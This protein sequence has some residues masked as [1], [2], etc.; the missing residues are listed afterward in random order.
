MNRRSFLSTSLASTA[1]A[2]PLVGNDHHSKGGENI[3]SGEKLA[4]QNGNSYWPICLDTATLDKGIGI[5]QKLRLAAE[6][7]FD[8]KEVELGDAV[9]ASDEVAGAAA[10]V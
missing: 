3:Q 2:A 10:V 5:E 4:W 1:V 6:A 8:V 9:S 7:G